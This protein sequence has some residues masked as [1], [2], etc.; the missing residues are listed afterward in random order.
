M[1]EVADTYCTAIRKYS[2]SNKAQYCTKYGRIKRAFLRRNLSYTNSSTYGPFKG[3]FQSTYLRVKDQP[4]YQEYLRYLYK[5]TTVF[6][7][8]KYL[9]SIREI[10][11]WMIT[12]TVT[13]HII[14]E[15]SK[16]NNMSR[17]NKKNNNDDN[18]NNKNDDNTN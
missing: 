8:Q 12:Y 14:F 10:Y 3:Y 4:E 7:T 16:Y 15:N 1:V 18:T 17:Y 11:E 9:Y 2:Q 5:I 13:V 6:S